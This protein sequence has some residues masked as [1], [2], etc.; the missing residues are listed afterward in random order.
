MINI[1]R[2]SG[3]ENSTSVKVNDKHMDRVVDLKTPPASQ[4]MINNRQ[5]KWI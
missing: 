4:V 3:S 5:G 1:R 2:G